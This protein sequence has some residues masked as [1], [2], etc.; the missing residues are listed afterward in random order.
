MPTAFV[1]FAS[2]RA[3]KIASPS[4]FDEIPIDPNAGPAQIAAQIAQQLRQRGYKSQG[5]LLALPATWC[6]CA[7]ISTAN[8]P[9]RDHAAMTFRLEEKL[10]LA[11]EN[12]TADFIVHEDTALGVCALNEKIQP[13]VEALEKS[14]VTLQSI[15]PAAILAMQHLKS[16]TG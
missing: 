13:L 14:G 15:S 6:L 16:P 5:A 11:A 7:S 2:D 3:W 4:A 10:P 9:D 1:I 12:I 8:L